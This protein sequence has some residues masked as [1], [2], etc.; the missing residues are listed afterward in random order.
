LLPNPFYVHENGKDTLYRLH[1]NNEPSSIGKGV[2]SGCIRLLNQDVI[3]LAK[4]VANGTA[5]I[6]IPD[7][8]MASLIIGGNRTKS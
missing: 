7:P 3:H 4:N 8:A 2:S 5:I 1:G 6:V